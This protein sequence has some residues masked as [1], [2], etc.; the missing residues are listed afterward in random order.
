MEERVRW[1]A[2]IPCDSSG[3]AVIS[4]K[5]SIEKDIQYAREKTVAAAFY[6][7]KRA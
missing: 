2:L 5:N 4:G 1:K 7:N 3:A 6:F